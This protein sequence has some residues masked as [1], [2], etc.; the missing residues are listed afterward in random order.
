LVIDEE[1]VETLIPE[2]LRGINDSQVVWPEFSFRKTGNL[3][4]IG[5]LLLPFFV[6]FLTYYLCA[7]INEAGFS[8][9]NWFPL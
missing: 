1:G 5:P 9:S 7:G 3:N 8:L 6:R 4:N 2:L